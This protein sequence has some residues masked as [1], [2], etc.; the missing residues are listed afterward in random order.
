[1]KPIPKLQSVNESHHQTLI[2]AITETHHQTPISA[3]ETH[4]QTSIQPPTITDPTT[5]QSCNP[6]LTN[7]NSDLCHH[8]NSTINA[9]HHKPTPSTTPIHKLRPPPLRSP[10]HTLHLTTTSQQHHMHR[11]PQKKCQRER[12]IDMR[13]ELEAYGFGFGFGFKQNQDI[14]RVQEG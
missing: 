7:P 3:T 12:P 10:T 4:H 8:Q 1:M 5:E 2:C 6:S 9:D 11:N 13:E 14:K